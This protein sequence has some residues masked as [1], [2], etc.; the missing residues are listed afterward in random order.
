MTSKKKLSSGI[1]A[2]EGY[3]RKAHEGSL[4]INHLGMRVLQYLAFKSSSILDLGCGE[5]T[6]LNLISTKKSK[7]FGIDISP[8]AISLA[9]KRFPHLNF[10]VGDIEKIP[11]PADTFDLV[12]SAF[13]FEHLDNP[14]KVIKEALR[15][16]KDNGKL[17]IVAPNY[18][19]PNRAS[20]PFKGSRLLKMARGAIQ[21]FNRQ[22]SLGWRRV[23]PSTDK[24]SID[25]DT[26][27]EPYL[28]SLIKYLKL[29]KTR[30]LLV[31]SCWDKEL[32]GA[33]FLQRLLGYL[34]NKNLYPF[35][36]WGP[37]LVLVAQ[38]SRQNR[39]C[40]ACGNER[41]KTLFEVKGREF[42][43]CTRCGLVKTEGLI[44]TEY[45][46][47]HRD[48]DYLQSEF[49]FR[50]FFLRRVKIIQNFINGPGKVLEVGSSI[51][52]FLKL[53]KDRGWEAWGVEPSGSANIARKRG[54]KILNQTIEEARLPKN[55]FDLI[56]LNHT[57]EHFENPTPILKKVRSLLQPKG[58]IFVDV[59]NFGGL[60][61]SVCRSR[62]PYLIPEEHYYQFA[63]DTLKKVF[64]KS[65]FRVIFT[66]SRS[67][68][69]DYGNPIGGL[70]DKLINM[71]KSFFTD[72]LGAIPAFLTT[73]AGKGSTLSVIG[74]KE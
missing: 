39:A 43:R 4:D 15:V 16:L 48:Q 56:V 60:S 32:K 68:I 50:N 41:Y 72:L 51:G 20:P 54:L 26:T 19:S 47:Y 24:Y 63:P 46:S 33:G 71:R 9:K 8:K 30:I 1:W 38:K 13:T 18:G 11:F 29:L 3:Y 69:W 53:F 61:A 2:R 22:K 49:L 6:R 17:V 28:G 67:G 10:L 7:N 44:L 25:S 37:H 34:G 73:I 55:Y 62:W 40:I 27:I 59:P 12:Y 45:E 14:E 52:T 57:L 70:M 21:D 5:G 74:E 42:S 64:E 58:K 66:G 35:W 65:G 31:D 23:I 36:M